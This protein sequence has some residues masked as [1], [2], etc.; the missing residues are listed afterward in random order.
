MT[1]PGWQPAE[2]YPPWALRRQ[3]GCPV[4]AAVPVPPGRA[5]QSMAAVRATAPETAPSVRRTLSLRRRSQQRLRGGIQQDRF[6]NARLFSRSCQTQRGQGQFVDLAENA[7][8]GLIKSLSCDVI[9]QRLGY[10]GGLELLCDGSVEVFALHPFEVILHCDVL[11][12]WIMDLHRTFG[13]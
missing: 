10:A 7:F 5:A 12:E 11:T 13:A 1:R 9:K 2:T 4:E 3:T 8:G 6:S